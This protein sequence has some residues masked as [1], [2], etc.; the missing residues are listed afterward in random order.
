M[1]L[2]ETPSSLRQGPTM[3]PLSE[4]SPWSP[5][6]LTS[7]SAPKNFLS[8]KNPRGRKRLRTGNESDPDRILSPLCGISGKAG[9][10]MVW[11]QGLSV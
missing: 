6:K 8:S 9:V 4:C 7:V 2:T 5:P 3:S 11:G 10:T 1:N